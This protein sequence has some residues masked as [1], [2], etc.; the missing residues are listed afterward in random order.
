MFFIVGIIFSVI[1]FVIGAYYRYVK[2]NNEKGNM[3][4]FKLTMCFR[5]LA[6]IFV[7]IG[8]V[9]FFLEGFFL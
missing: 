5:Y 8:V 6:F 1:S 3:N 2:N 9:M 4:Y 7:A